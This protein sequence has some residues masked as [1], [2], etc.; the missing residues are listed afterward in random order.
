M[1]LIYNMLLSNL[2]GRAISGL[3]EEVEEEIWLH[4]HLL[5]L[6]DICYSAL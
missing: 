5:F 6:L 3:G 2:S 1:F 4:A